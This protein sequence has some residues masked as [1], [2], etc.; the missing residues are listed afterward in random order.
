VYRN[1]RVLEGKIRV[2]MEVD[3]IRHFS[4]IPR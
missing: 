2:D 4:M 1:R 3:K